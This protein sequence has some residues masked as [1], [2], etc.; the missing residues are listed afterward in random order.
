MLSK[1]LIKQL[2]KTYTNYSNKF[3]ITVHQG[4][5]TSYHQRLDG[6]CANRLQI[7]FS[8]FIDINDTNA[9]HNCNDA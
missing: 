7:Q 2:H 5:D 4:D 9:N 3:Y 6:K 1:L 8:S